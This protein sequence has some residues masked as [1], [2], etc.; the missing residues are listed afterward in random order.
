MKIKS[1][2]IIL[3]L[4]LSCQKDF[5]LDDLDTAE[6]QI[7]NL[8]S[9]L[10]SVQTENT[11]LSSEKQELM[12]RIQELQNQIE[13]AEISLEVAEEQIR[14]Y[15]LQIAVLEGIKDGL[16]KSIKISSRMTK[17]EL[18]KGEFELYN[19][20]PEAIEKYAQHYKV[21]NEMVTYSGQ[22]YYPEEIQEED[23]LAS[24]SSIPYVKKNTW[25][26]LDSFQPSFS[27]EW[28]DQLRL[29][30]VFLE[31]TLLLKVLNGLTPLHLICPKIALLECT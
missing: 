24:T 17:E 28:I 4:V 18:E 16:Y 3:L 26:L 27:V 11:N 20:S 9:Q 23:G 29:G 12:Q 21:T 1:I 31:K 5:Y 15:G 30:Y 2:L 13:N 25:H 8:Q 7:S 14:A 22:V 19:Y 6:E 10:N